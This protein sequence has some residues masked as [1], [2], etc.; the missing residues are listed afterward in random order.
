M[1]LIAVSEGPVAQLATGFVVVSVDAGRTVHR[2]AFGAAARGRLEARQI[3]DP[4]NVQGKTAGSSNAHSRSRIRL[5][6]NQRYAVTS[7]GTYLDLILG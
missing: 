5:P 3:R 7:G 6:S 4:L 1:P 2:Q